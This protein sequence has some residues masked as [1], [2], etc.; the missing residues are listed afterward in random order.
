M[1]DWLTRL[2]DRPLGESERRAALIAVTA[3]LIA[4]TVLLAT[5]RA[6]RHRTTPERQP[7]TAMRGR[8]PQ[9]APIQI[10][11][12]GVVLSPQAVRVS[13]R[14]LSGYLAY[15]YGR[16]GVDGVRD[17]SR[18]LERSLR[19]HPPRVS[20]DMRARHPHILKLHQVPGAAS[21]LEVT[22]LIADG[23]VA[24]YPVGLLLASEHGHLE[25]TGLAQGRAG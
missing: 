5:T 22:A 7:A 3:L 9:P 25:V 15:I 19:A 6:A 2:R 18:A 8:A 17:A 12:R 14:F 13:R 4:S 11:M 24:D 20:R 23:G 1:G 10:A 16:A 21:Q